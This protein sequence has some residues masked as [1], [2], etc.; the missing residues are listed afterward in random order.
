MEMPYSTF[1]LILQAAE[2]PAHAPYI[3]PGQGP[4][5]LVQ[6]THLS[7]HQSQKADVPDTEKPVPPDCVEHAYYIRPHIYFRHYNKSF[8][9]LPE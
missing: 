1:P 7:T 9:W 3:P 5:S 2:P 8:R 6:S 4:D